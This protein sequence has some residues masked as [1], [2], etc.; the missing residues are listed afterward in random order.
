VTDFKNCETRLEC[1]RCGQTYDAHREAVNTC[2][3]CGSLLEVK[4]DFER[5]AGRNVSLILKG[6]D[7][8]DPMPLWHFK[9]LLPH[10]L[11]SDIVTLGEGGSP[12]RRLGSVSESLG[13]KVYAKYYGTNPTGTHKDL[14]MS[15]AVSMAKELKVRTALTFSTGNAATSLAAYANLA[16]IRTIVLTRSEISREKLLNILALG[17]TV[18]QVS[19]LDDPWT[20]LNE[21]QRKTHLY[22]FTNFVNPFRAEGHKTLAYEVFARLHEDVDF[23][24]CPLGTGGGLWGAWKGFKEMRMLGVMNHL[25]RMVAVQPEAVMHTV[26]AFKEGKEI[27]K[28]FGEGHHT[29]V[30]SLADS[31]PFYGAARPLRALK[32]SGGDAV[33]VSDQEVIT[34]IFELG[35]E[36]YFV[37]P[38]AATALAALKREVDDGVIDKGDTVVLSLTGTGLKQP[39]AIGETVRNGVVKIKMKDL[40]RLSKIAA[41]ELI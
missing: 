40:D 30:Q 3:K 6:S 38:A 2:K 22:A 11:N 23:V 24:I 12:I 31:E 15:V 25:P 28:A 10:P 29:V 34:S 32:E 36:G 18:V 5:T 21:V 26:K 1:E 8:R 13:V 16:G 37:E 19:G 41:G 35:K 14:G 17:A 20:V 9:N 4:Y 33:A 27:A 7:K 39:E